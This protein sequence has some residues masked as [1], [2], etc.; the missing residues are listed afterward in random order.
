LFN[1]FYNETIFRIKRMPNQRRGH[2]PN[3]TR[4]P[5]DEDAIRSG[6][7]GTAC[8]ERAAP[9]ILTATIL[10]SSMAFID[11]TSTNL[12]LPAL[13]Q[14]LGA[15]AIDLQWVVQAYALFLSSL[16]LV[17]GALGDRLG[18]RRVFASGI[19]LFT[20]ASIW[21]G[22]APSV[23]QLIVARA[24]QGI[25]AAL[26]VPGSLAIISASF[27][28]ERRGRA[29]G[30]W[31]GFSAL[32]TA[33]G[34]VIGGWLVEH[35]SWRWVFFM[36]VPLAVI[37]LLLLFFWVP[38]SRDDEAQH[39]LDWWGAGLA[40]VGLGGIV[41]GLTESSAFGFGSPLVWG[42]LAVGVVGLGAFLLVEARIR[43]PLMPLH[44]FRSRSFSGAN[45]LTLLLYTALGG[46]LFFLPLNLIQ[47]QGYTA[48]T[49][50]LALL[51]FVL[52]M[53][54]LSRWAGGLINRYGA[55]L[56]LMVGP[57]IV[58]VGFAL[59]ALP[60]IGGSYWVTFFPG[61]L[62]LSLGMAISVAPLTTTVMSAVATRHAGVASGINNAIARTAGLLAVA[63]MGAIM[64]AAFGSSLDSRAAAFDLAPEVRQELAAE[65]TDLGGAQVPP[66]VPDDTAAALEQAIKRAFVDGFRLI[67]LVAAG[68]ALASALSAAWLIE[69]GVVRAAGSEQAPAS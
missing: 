61:I 69:R 31:S 4:N 46:V 5:C 39:G 1:P 52:I 6:K 59:L 40:T 57:T 66:G 7:A 25:G 3:T 56:P 13:Q 29:I 32:T 51:P 60:A 15:T 18:R 14:D 26:L 47:V 30:T 44:L 43:A 28:E 55:R 54:V 50:G 41:Y 42:A 67:M 49:A 20:L 27:D 65:R 37:V 63:V 10:A 23:S 35:V 9:W 33:L 68:L 8:T 34:P 53:F 64:I 22:L 2:M 38:E 16:I 62:V 19:V 12:A 36:N 11:S 58:A 17:G 48:T 24:V 45:L 21:C